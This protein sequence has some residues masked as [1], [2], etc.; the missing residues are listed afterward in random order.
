MTRDLCQIFKLD[1]P[2]QHY[3]WGSY[4]AIAE[5][6]GRKAPADRPEAELWMGAHPKAPSMVQVGG[7][8]VPMP[9]VIAMDPEAILGL[10]TARRFDARMPFLFKVLA[11][12]EPLSIQAH[13]NQDQARAGF[14]RENQLDIPLDA[15]HRNFRDDAHKPEIICALTPFWAMNGFQPLAAI[16]SNLHTYAPRTLAPM[17]ARLE[18]RDTSSALKEFF[19]TLL[20]LSDRNRQAIIAEVTAQAAENR[21]A[22]P[23]ANWVLRLNEAYPGDIGV[24]APIYLNLVCLPPGEAMSLSA[25]QLHAYLEGVGIELMANSDNV[26]RGGL[27]P[28]HID[29]RELLRVMQFNAGK[30]RRITPPARPEVEARY[31]TAVEEFELA[32]LD[33]CDGRVFTSG[34]RRSIEILLLTEGAVIIETVDGMRQRHLRQGESVLIPACLKSY[35]IEGCGRLYRASVP[36]T[37]PEPA[38]ADKK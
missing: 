38:S 10:E 25:G 1:N 19:E 8:K 16:A 22:D 28:K 30:P 23:A 3:A 18:G 2:I 21:V 32:R 14:R 31:P 37:K 29:R 15:P 35:R 9:D 24:L 13:P 7:Q 12:A 26:L 36:Q 4:T 20:Q 17:A 27:T 11:A 6:M 33:V 5:L 34:A